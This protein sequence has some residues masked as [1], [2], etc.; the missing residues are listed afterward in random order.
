MTELLTAQ[1]IPLSKCSNEQQMKT[2]KQVEKALVEIL[3][4]N[5]IRDELKLLIEDSTFQDSDGNDLDFCINDFVWNLT[6]DLKPSSVADN[7][8][9]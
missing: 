4:S 1:T 7:S 3:S 9:D 8:N 6:L 2:A 5:C